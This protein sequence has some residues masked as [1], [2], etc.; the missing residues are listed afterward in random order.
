MTGTIISSM[1]FMVLVIL[2]LVAILLFVKAKLTPKGTVQIDIND[3]KKVLSVAP[4]GSL[5]NTLAEN[6]IFL[7]SACGG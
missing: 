1:L 7:P 6:Q 2:F 4:G 3:G 5:M